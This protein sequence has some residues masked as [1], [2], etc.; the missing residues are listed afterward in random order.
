M[1]V[2]SGDITRN[3]RSLRGLA[4]L[5]V[6][7]IG[8]SA[9]GG[10]GTTRSAPQL[11]TTSQPVATTKPPSV[12]TAV[13]QDSDG[14]KWEFR[15]D[16]AS[17]ETETTFGIF[18]AKPKQALIVLWNAT[19]ENLTTDRPSP[20]PF[21]GSRI[22]RANRQAMTAYL[23]FPSD[24]KCSRSAYWDSESLCVQLLAVS[25]ID[26][27][28]SDKIGAGATDGFSLYTSTAAV[29]ADIPF[30]RSFIYVYW[31]LDLIG[32]KYLDGTDITGNIMSRI[33]LGDPPSR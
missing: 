33:A 13:V 27:D 8:L 29:P 25:G 11:P 20:V 32:A 26:Q 31:G 7:L 6:V 4:L 2:A 19:V 21:N 12:L 3:G 24:E 14:W 22:S 16:Y 18:T 17:V 30:D 9:C 28:L 23:A 15:F 10:D 1:S 5:V